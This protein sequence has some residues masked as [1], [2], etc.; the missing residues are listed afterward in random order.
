MHQHAN[1]Y[2]VHVT[3]TCSKMC[4]PQVS[5]SAHGS[6]HARAPKM[7]AALE[8]AVGEMPVREDAE[9]D[10]EEIPSLE[11]DED[12]EEDDCGEVCLCALGVRGSCEC[13]NRLT[14]AMPCSKVSLLPYALSNHTP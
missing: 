8:D 12:C 13:I 14:R 5:S 6:G 11:D 9:D 3:S 10:E 2:N 7:Q 1:T 4:A